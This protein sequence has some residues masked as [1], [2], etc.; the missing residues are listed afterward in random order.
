MGDSIEPVTTGKVEATTSSNTVTAAPTSKTFGSDS[1]VKIGSMQDLQAKA[2]KVYEAMLLGIAS[3]VCSDM[4]ESQERIKQM[5][6]EARY[7]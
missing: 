6:R 5:N 1:N 3:N 4:K 2:P 7:R